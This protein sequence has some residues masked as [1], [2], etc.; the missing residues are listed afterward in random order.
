VRQSLDSER[1]HLVTE[2]GQD[3]WRLVNRAVINDPDLALD[4]E[5]LE[6]G[7]PGPDSRRQQIPVVIGGDHKRKCLAAYL[8]RSLPF[9]FI[10]AHRPGRLSVARI[11]FSARRDGMGGHH[12][13]VI[14]LVREIVQVILQLQLLHRRSIAA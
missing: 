1:W 4:A 14:D 12:R 7:L 11:L 9:V 13:V 10:L 8:G 3:R 6:R 5:A 2:I